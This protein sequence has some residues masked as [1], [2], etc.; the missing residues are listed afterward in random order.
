MKKIAYFSAAVTA[1][2]VAAAC[3]D[4]EFVIE[5]GTDDTD[6]STSSSSSS[7][8]SKPTDGGRDGRADGSTDSGK[9]SG[10]DADVDPDSGNDA[11]AGPNPIRTIGIDIQAEFDVNAPEAPSTF[12]FANDTNALDASSW[13]YHRTSTGGDNQKFELYVQLTA[14]AAGEK[15]SPAVAQIHEY[16]GDVTVADLASVKVHSRREAAG[17][18]PDFTTL[19]YTEPN[20][21]DDDASWFGYRLH[22]ELSNAVGKNA[23]AQ[24][25]NEFGTG[26][27]VNGLQFWDYRNSNVG[28]GTAPTNNYFTLE[29]MQTG[30]VTPAGLPS[31]RD[32][33][34]EKIKYL[35]F[36]SYSTAL[37]F[38]AQLD[39]IE[40]VLKNGKGVFLDLSGDKSVRRFSVSH[41]AITASEP[42]SAGS[43]Y[44]T[45]LATD[46]FTGGT[47]WSYVRS[48]AGNKFEFYVPFAM[49][50]AQA[51]PGAAWAD[52]R[53]LMGE[54]TVAQI[55]S[56]SVRSRRN[57]ATSADF[58]MLVYTRPVD[59]ALDNDKTW[60]RRK[61]TGAAAFVTGA[62]LAE[63]TWN[64][65]TTS[66]G[67]QFKFWDFKGNDASPAGVPFTLADMQAGEVAA[68]TR[69]YRAETVKWINF[70]TFSD[71]TD[72]DAAIDSIEI[73]LQDR[74]AILDLNK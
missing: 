67:N 3:G 70:S 7:S 38:D 27:A 59:G 50:A 45:P 5:P 17:E 12:G 28:A 11:E 60:Y 23:P 22:S 10:N 72:A 32:Y 20:G 74:T 8:G 15:V 44:G 71:Q 14:A 41:A 56:I 57:T 19:I 49:D 25:W 39:G 4:D 54:F 65:Q 55:N 58:S 36:A 6:A 9:D 52:L 40:V 31:A 53:T 13:R 51:P 46:S 35:T 18:A 37:D 34:A 68:T 66:A 26:A 69:D 21:V 47:S 61:L 42:P 29:Q 33:R 24:T 64:L 16:L 2:I 48:G 63:D 43:T 1:M 30:P 62:P 73:K